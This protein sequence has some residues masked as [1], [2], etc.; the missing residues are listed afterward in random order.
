MLQEVLLKHPVLKAHYCK[1]NTLARVLNVSIKKIKYYTDKGILPYIQLGENFER[2][3]HKKRTDKRLN[4]IQRLEKRGKTI[5][6]L[7]SL[8]HK[9][10]AEHRLSEGIRI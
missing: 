3:Y 1:K 5:D 10:V 2:Y 7:R 9:D 8:Y 4:E 6:E